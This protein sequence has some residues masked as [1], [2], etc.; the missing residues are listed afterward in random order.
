MRGPDDDVKGLK[1]YPP[2]ELAALISY[3]LGLFMFIAAV[4]LGISIPG[5]IRRWAR[6]KSL[7]LVKIPITVPIRRTASRYCIVVQVTRD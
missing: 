7:S 3:N 5:R 2:R 4:K 1:V 6:S